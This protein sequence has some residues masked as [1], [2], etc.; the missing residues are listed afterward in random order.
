MRWVKHVAHMADI[1][2]VYNLGVVRKI[3]LKWILKQLD[4]RVWT[5]FIRLVT[6]T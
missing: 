4:E 3:I 2:S 1:R 5:G 6:G